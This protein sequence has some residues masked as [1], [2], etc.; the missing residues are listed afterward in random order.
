MLISYVIGVAIVVTVSVSWVIV[1]RRW[2][3][4]FLDVAPD[5]DP[6][7]ARGTCHDC[8]LPTVCDASRICDTERNSS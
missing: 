3:S 6:L 8:A 2:R 7:A 1:Q 5:P 4:A